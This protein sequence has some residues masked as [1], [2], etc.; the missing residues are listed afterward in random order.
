M[1]GHIGLRFE[2]ALA[3]ARS[4]VSESRCR[5]LQS[6]SWSLRRRHTSRAASIRRSSSGSIIGSDRALR[7][8][9]TVAGRRPIII[10]HHNSRRRRASSQPKR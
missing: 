2:L 9:G 7:H 3:A 1:A 8:V 4:T 10:V 6:V 5:L